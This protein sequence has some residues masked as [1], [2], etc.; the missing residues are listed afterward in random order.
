MT[1]GPHKTL[2]VLALDGEK[3]LVFRNEGDAEY[4]VLKPVDIDKQDVP[5]RQDLITDRPG[6]KSDGNQHYSAMDEVDAHD[7]MERR[8]AEDAIEQLNEAALKN[9]FD[10][11]LIYAASHS[12][13]EIRPHYHDELKT[14]LI[15]EFDIDV[16]NE[17]VDKLEKRVS[18]ALKDA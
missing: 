15:G 16:V 6:R 14:R 2:W 5:Q 8:F 13:G 10:S 4:P 12:L 7:Q 17:P 18:K 11:L 1:H 3:A 9:E